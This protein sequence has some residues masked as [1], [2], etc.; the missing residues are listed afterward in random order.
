MIKCIGAEMLA[1]G[2]KG[3][4][5]ATAVAQEAFRGFAKIAAAQYWNNVLRNIGSQIRN[6]DGY[7]I[8]NGV[9]GH[10]LLFRT[11][12]HALYDGVM[13]LLGDRSEVKR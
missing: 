10:A 13:G 3:R 11:D 6:N 12:Q 2:I 8:N 1:V 7:A 5:G 9:F 4:P